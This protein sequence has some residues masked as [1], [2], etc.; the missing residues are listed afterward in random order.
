M[1]PRRLFALGVLLILS[2]LAVT[3]CRQE[4]QRRYHASQTRLA[5][6]CADFRAAESDVVDPCDLEKTGPKVIPIYVQARADLKAAKESRS[7]ARSTRRR[8]RTNPAR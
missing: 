4:T 6:Q 2:G 3:G 5:A 1:T 8:R 7:S